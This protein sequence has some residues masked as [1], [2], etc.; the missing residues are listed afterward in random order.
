M[1]YMSPAFNKI[2]NE[3]FNIVDNQTRE[4]V[5]SLNEAEQ[6]KL[7]SKLT[8]KLYEHI[9]SRVTD[10]DF[11]SIPK[12]KGDIT[13]LDNYENLV[14]CIN[15]IESLLTQYKQKLDPITTIK[16]A[17]ENI[18][19]M[20]N[21]FEMGFKLNDE[22]ICMI[23]ST[24][25]LAIVSSTSF[26]ISTCIEYIKS[27]NNELFEISL[28][29]V[30]LSKTKDNLL[31][32][33]L[34][35]FN[36]TCKKGDMAKILDYSVQKGSKHL[37]GIGDA[38]VVM[39]AGLIIIIIFN[40]IP[41]IRELIYFFYYSRVRLSDYFDIQADL[42][43]MNIYNLERN[44]DMDPDTRKTIIEKQSKIVNIFR[45]IS[46]KINISNKQSENKTKSDISKDNLKFNVDKHTGE[47]DMEKTASTLF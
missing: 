36:I 9:T 40:I 22:F 18:K 26:L 39:N 34:K 23:Y 42:L 12:T 31:F 20:K 13:K 32:D 46:N 1:N 28:D 45:N 14:D 10:I 6:D 33:N 19:A 27:P 24:V 4:H 5:L 3:Y 35:R 37:L 43:Q 41:M 29:K 47:L 44:S 25:S 2:I 15:T 30:S 38:F 17:L 8:T 21:Q 11:G 16:E 7:L